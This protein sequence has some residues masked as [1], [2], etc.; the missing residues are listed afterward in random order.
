[1]SKWNPSDG[2]RPAKRPDGWPTRA[3]VQW[4]SDAELAIYKAMEAVEKAGGS[5][6]LTDAITLLSKA[7]SRVADHVEGHTVEGRIP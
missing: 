4:F 1:M 5:G 2:P 7:R 6:A 3:D